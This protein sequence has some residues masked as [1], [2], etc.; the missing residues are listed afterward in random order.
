MVSPS[1]MIG[2]HRSPDCHGDSKL[3]ATPT[4]S[5]SIVNYQFIKKLPSNNCICNHG[6]RVCR[7][8][9][10]VPPTFRESSPLCSVQ[11]GRRA[12]LRVS[13]LRYAMQRTF[14]R[15]PPLC[16]SASGYCS[17]VIADQ[18]FIEWFFW[19]GSFLSSPGHP[20]ADQ[21]SAFPQRPG[22]SRRGHYSC[23]TDAAS[24]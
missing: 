6:T 7:A 21:E 8:Y 14:S 13:F 19:A 5:L 3:S 20:A 11:A 18:L 9:F 23:R 1:A 10:V 15:G 22:L 17:R 2:I 12:A 4:P 24:A 16:G